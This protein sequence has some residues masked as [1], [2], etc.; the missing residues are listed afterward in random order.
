MESTV[1]QPCPICF[2][3]EGLTMIAHTS[4]IPYFG[5]HTQLTILC[6]SCGWKHTD[7]IPAEGKKP[8]AWSLEID[9]TEMLSV[10]IVRSSSCTIRIEKLG[11]EVDPGGATTGYVSNI[12]GVLNR[13]EGAIQ[14][15]YRQS[16]S[17]KEQNIVEK[18]ESL[19]KKIDLVKSGEL[20][21]KMTLLDPMGHSQILHSNAIS[22]DLTSEELENLE[23]GPSIPIF[24][25]DDV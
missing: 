17:S 10:R 4:E 22:R 14:L 24:S 12:E 2:S 11:L 25:P 1:E 15:M 6:P 3:E 16:I 18:C 19:L 13:F 21:V 9:S 7:F 8:G 5:E 20:V 23:L